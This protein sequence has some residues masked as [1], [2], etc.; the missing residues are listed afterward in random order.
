M[1]VPRSFLLLK[2]SKNSTS[3]SKIMHSESEKIT[4]ETEK[5]DIDLA[6]QLAE[7]LKAGWS[8]QDI[9]RLARMRACYTR[10]EYDR[11]LSPT[12]GNFSLYSHLSFARWLYQNKRLF[13]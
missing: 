10:R 8:E 13:S 1:T 12:N 3:H 7:L 9:V 6:E 2:S 11:I 4:T 5:V